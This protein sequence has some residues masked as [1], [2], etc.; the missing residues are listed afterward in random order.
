MIITKEQSGEMLEAA[1]PLIK[2]MNDNCHP[3]TKVIVET[4]RAELVEGV[5]SVLTQEFI[6]D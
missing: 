6:K 1:K 2:W 3:H 4:D 5:A